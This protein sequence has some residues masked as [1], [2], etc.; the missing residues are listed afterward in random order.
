MPMTRV[1]LFEAKQ[2]LSELVQRAAAGEEIVITRHGQPA[3]VLR[4]L[5]PGIDATGARAAGRRIAARRKRLAPVTVEEILRWI[6][7]GRR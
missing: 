6:G 1:G 3:A 5:R 7:E 2:K 4:G